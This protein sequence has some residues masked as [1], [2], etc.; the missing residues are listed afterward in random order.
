MT[1]IAE[2]NMSELLKHTFLLLVVGPSQR[3][4]RPCTDAALADAPERAGGQD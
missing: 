1:G 4:R 2:K 3:S